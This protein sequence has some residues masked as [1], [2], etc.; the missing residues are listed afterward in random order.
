MRALGSHTEGVGRSPGRC[1]GHQL[2]VGSPA[3]YGSDPKKEWKTPPPPRSQLGSKDPEAWGWTLGYLPLLSLIFHP[4]SPAVLPGD[5]C[6][7]QVDSGVGTERALGK[8]TG[9]Q[10]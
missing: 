1:W 3:G 6:L 7:T 4:A 8:E 9:S 10:G 2:V 5:Y